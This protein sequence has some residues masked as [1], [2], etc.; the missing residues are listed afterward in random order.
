MKTTRL[1]GV[2]AFVLSSQLFASA[3]PQK[4]TKY[5][6]GPDLS[7][8]TGSL[9]ERA[10]TRRYPEGIAYCNRAVESSLKWEIINMY[11][12]RLG[13]HIGAAERTQYKIDHFYPL[14]A[15]G[16]NEMENLWPQHQSV[17]IHTDQLEQEVCNK[18][19]A[20]RLKQRDAIALI[21]KA[22]LDLSQAAATLSYVRGL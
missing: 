13:Y 11:N 3:I 1:F 4:N 19:A 14:C 21:R 17:Y 12:D 6:I 20:G 9:C 5:P 7:V 15:G 8:T 2:L 18:M 22:K 16:S 10:D